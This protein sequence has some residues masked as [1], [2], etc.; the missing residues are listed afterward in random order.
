MSSLRVVFITIC[1]SLLS[2]NISLE[3]HI[4]RIIFTI[5]FCPGALALTGG[6]G[7]KLTD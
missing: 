5:T 6:G 7:A 2:F 1:M 3:A 4:P